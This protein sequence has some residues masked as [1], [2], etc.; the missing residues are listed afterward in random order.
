MTPEAID[1]LVLI[2]LF[3]LLLLAV[4]GFEQL[5]GYLAKR[6]AKRFPLPDLLRRQPQAPRYRRTQDGPDHERFALKLDQ[7]RRQMEGVR[8]GR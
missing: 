4:C 1:W 5:H 7:R 6:R 2:F 8:W 3:G